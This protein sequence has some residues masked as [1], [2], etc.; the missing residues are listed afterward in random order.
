M[1]L[2]EAYRYQ[3]YLADLLEQ[4]RRKFF[5]PDLI[6]K[7]KTVHKKSVATRGKVEDVIVESVNP[8]D[9]SAEDIIN[10]CVKIIDEK[11]KLTVAIDAAKKN[12]SIDIDSSIAMNITK[13]GLISSLSALANVK[14][15]SKKSDAID[16]IINDIDGKQQVYH[17]EA[18][19]VKSID[20]DRN[21]VKGLIKRLNRECDSVSEQ[22]DRINVTTNVNYTPIWDVNESLDDAIAEI[23]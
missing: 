6:T 7:S 5:E 9:Y 13:R 2:K 10:F 1:V 15:E 3:N 18:E 16:Y 4:A 8:Y 14:P 19:T 12:A 22:L 21:E 11:E 17:Y 23:Q 20:F